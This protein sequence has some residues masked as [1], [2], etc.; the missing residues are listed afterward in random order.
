M[1]L[2]DGVYPRTRGRKTDIHLP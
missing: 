1:S 2:G